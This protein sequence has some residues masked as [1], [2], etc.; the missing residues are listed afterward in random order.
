MYRVVLYALMMTNQTHIRPYLYGRH[1]TER[2]INMIYKNEQQLRFNHGDEVIDALKD[3]IKTSI[4][5]GK[6][7]TISIDDIDK[8]VKKLSKKK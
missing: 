1:C 8:E 7:K 6:C 5:S 4:K 3:A 2:G